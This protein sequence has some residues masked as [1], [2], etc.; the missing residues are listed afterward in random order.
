ALLRAD[1][2]DDVGPPDL[3]ANLVGDLQL[4][5]LLA[6]FHDGADQA[7]GGQHAVADLEGAEHLLV[8]ALLLLLG[9]NEE[10]VE[11]PEHQEEWNHHRE[12]PSGPSGPGAT[13]GI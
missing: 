11:H 6:A 2:P 5:E 7:A 12:S 1:P 4:D 8:Q 3:H 9:A 10:K 13:L